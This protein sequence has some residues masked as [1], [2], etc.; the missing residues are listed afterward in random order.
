MDDLGIDTTSDIRLIIHG[1]LDHDGDIP[2]RIEDTYE[3]VSNDVWVS[4]E[5]A[6]QIVAHLTK[7]FKLE[8]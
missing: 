8:V 3:G 6:A 2:I 4:R 5:D 1:E 7:V